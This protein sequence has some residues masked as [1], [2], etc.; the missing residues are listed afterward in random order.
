[1]TFKDASYTSNH[2]YKGNC[3]IPE[4]NNPAVEGTETEEAWEKE[5]GAD[6]EWLSPLYTNDVSVEE[7][8]TAVRTLIQSTRA[9]ER[10][11]LVEVVKGIVNEETPPHVTREVRDT[12]AMRDRINNRLAKISQV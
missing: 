3:G 2:S 7:K 8:K 1:M 9:D 6:S 11:K 4:H 5:H 12:D 10:A